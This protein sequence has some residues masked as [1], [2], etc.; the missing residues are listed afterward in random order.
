MDLDFFI[1]FSFFWG[2]GILFHL[3]LSIIS[4]ESYIIRPD[5]F[6]NSIFMELQQNA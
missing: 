1:C 2:G 5:R 4:L 6:C 3:Y